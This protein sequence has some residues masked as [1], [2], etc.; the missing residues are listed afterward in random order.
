MLRS[1]RTGPTKIGSLTRASTVIVGALVALFGVIAGPLLGVLATSASAATT[2]S[3]Y[4]AITPYRALGTSAAGAPVVA[5]TPATVQI[6]SSTAGEVPA[7]ATA[8]VLNVTASAPTSAGYLEV[9]PTGAAATNPTSNVNFVA[10][11]TVANLVTVPLSASGSISVLNFA[12]TTAVD[13]DV[14]GFY[15]AAGAGLYNPVSPVRVAGTAAAG[16]PIAANTAVPVTVTGGTIPTSASAVVVNLT[17]AGG[18]SASYLSAYAAGAT[19]AITSSLNFTAGETVANRDIVNVGTG[20]QIEV[21]NFAGSVNVDVDVN[22]YYAGT[23]G[24]FVPLASPVRL[25][26]TRFNLATTASGIPA[27]ASAVAANFTV[28]PGEAPGY[29]TV[30][31][32]G[33]TTA[34]TASDVNWPASSGPVPNFTQADTA[35]TTAGS[36]QVYNLN[37]GSPID[38]VIDAFGYFTGITSGVA[39]VATPSTVST[40]QTGGVNDS[41]VVA[42]VTNAGTPVVGDTVAVTATPSTT[43]SCGTI[44]ATG[45]T[46]AGGTVTL[47]YVGTAVVGTCTIKVTEANNGLSGT[48]VITQAANNS[49]AVATGGTAIAPH[50]VVESTGGGVVPNAVTATV[51][52]PAAAPVVGETVNFTLTPE[53]SGGCGT[54]T[55]PSEVTAA[56]GI[57][58]DNYNSPFV[59]GLCLITATEATA[60]TGESAPQSGTTYYNSTSAAVPAATTVTFTPAAASVPENTP[61]TVTVTVTGAAAAVIPSDPVFLTVTPTTAA[62]CGTLSATAGVTN[63]SGVATF[64]YTA[65]AAAGTCTIHAVE[66]HNNIAAAVPEV[67]TQTANNSVVVAASPSSVVDSGTAT[68]TVTATVTSSTG[69]AVSGDVVSFTTV[70]SPAGSCGTFTPASAG[71]TNSSGVVSVTYTSSTTAGFCTITAT[72]NGTAQTGTVTID[73]T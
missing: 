52:T 9:Y 51:T 7:G 38:V 69:S 70:A 34:P 68:S 54:L 23:G 14:E 19:P 67:I 36:A 3:G 48:A 56:G 57:A 18:T 1:S 27:T 15:S 37:S 39:V 72:E 28:V 11:E 17:A 41:S 10:G 71:S 22:G 44:P 47:A 53:T 46:I 16:T 61:A 25:T 24:A 64:T 66:S 30:F 49:V 55:A 2:G 29:I 35:G 31:P 5:G 8:A 73:Q 45:I 65:G 26:D 4:T 21:Y 13:V 43:G 60:Q 12:G 50:T 6:T 40:G 59:T 42:T 32:T 33:V 63:A 58:T 62:T 20:G